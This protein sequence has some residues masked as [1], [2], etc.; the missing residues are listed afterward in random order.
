MVISEISG[1]LM[2]TFV[3]VAGLAFVCTS[4]VH[5][6]TCK[7][8]QTAYEAA[9]YSRAMAILQPLAAKG[10]D[11]A[12]YQLGEMHMLGRGVPEDKAKARELFKQAA[13]KGNGKAKVMASFLDKK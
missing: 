9:N 10:D 12:Q 5:A 7:D 2:R 8:G 11:C 6:E 3:A 1:A 13:A 4:P